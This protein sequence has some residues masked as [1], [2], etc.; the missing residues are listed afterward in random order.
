MTSDQADDVVRAAGTVVWRASDRV[1]GVA[2]A[3]GQQ[4]EVLLVHRPRYDDWSFPKGKLDP[5][6]HVVTAAVRETHEET[7]LTVTLCAPLP[8]LRYTVTKGAKPRPKVVSYWAARAVR[9][10]IAD[11]EPNLE[12]DR[13]EWQEVGRARHNLTYEHDAALLDNVTAMTTPTTP[14]VILRHAEAIP[15]ERWSDRDEDRRLSEVGAAQ[16]VDMTELLGAYGIAE[17]ITSRAA[18]C[19]D[20]VTPYVRSRADDEAADVNLAYEDGLVDV[21]G[22]GH[23]SPAPGTVTDRVR[24]TLERA[25]RNVRRSVPTAVCTHRPVLGEVFAGLGLAA[26]ALS[27]GGFTV[28][29]CGPDGEIIAIE[30]HQPLTR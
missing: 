29:H 5:G 21:G 30:D 24:P 2:S 28:A 19:L 26:R 7:G 4:L 16:A 11:Y 6:E 18:R 9:G 23:D 8:T 1:A 3:A 15:R 20:T 10:S 13:L 22:G 27:A 12:V 17:V 25:L 14:L